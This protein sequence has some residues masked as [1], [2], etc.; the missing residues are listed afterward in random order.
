MSEDTW[1]LAGKP[2]WDDSVSAMKFSLER[3]GQTYLCAI[4]QVALTDHFE[5][6]DS[7]QAA[8]KNYHDHSEEVHLVA[9]RLIQNGQHNE[10][11]VFFITS[12]AF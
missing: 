3:D 7:K 1:Q 11:G 2:W 9:I 4:S 8:I 10:H 6:D 5:T 12:N